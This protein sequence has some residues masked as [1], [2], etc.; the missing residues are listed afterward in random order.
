[1]AIVVEDGSGVAG[2]NSYITVAEARAYAAAHGDA[3]PADDAAAETLLA[4][5]MLYL[6]ARRAEYQGTKAS[7]DNP[8]QWPRNSVILDG[9]PLAVGT[10]P[11]E[12]KDAQ[13]Q[14]AIEA[15]TTDLMPTGDGREV[16]MEQVDV[17]RV[18]YAPSGSTSLQ[19]RLAK[20]EALLQPLYGSGSFS[21]LHSVRV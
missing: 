11:R 12:L 1:M 8:L 13:A 19:P 20:V 4:R 2:A 18:Q 15:Q 6:E 14:L 17:I 5:A 7:P 10:I 9:Y 3:L 21:R 16:I